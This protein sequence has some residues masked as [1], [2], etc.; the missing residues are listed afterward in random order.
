MNN[1][2]APTPGMAARASGGWHDGRE[3]SRNTP[4]GGSFLAA[5]DESTG[6]SGNMER[7]A[8]IGDGRSGPFTPP[9]GD[10]NGTGITRPIGGGGGVAPE[11]IAGL[12]ETPLAPEEGPWGSATTE[13]G[14]RAV[15]PETPATEADGTLLAEGLVG[16]DISAETEGEFL[17]GSIGGGRITIYNEDNAASELTFRWAKTSDDPSTWNLYYLTNSEAEGD[18]I[19]W[20]RVPTDFVFGED[21]KLTEPG[22]SSVTLAGLSVDG[23]SF[24]D[25]A[26]SFGTNGLSQAADATGEVRIAHLAQNGR[27]EMARAGIVGHVIEPGEEQ[28][29]GGEH[30]VVVVQDGATG[31]DGDNGGGT[32]IT[33]NSADFAIMQRSYIA[34]ALSFGLGARAVDLFS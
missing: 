9:V 32:G 27:D 26:L 23:T 10:G 19:T 31:P 5:M 30:G 14:Y 18:A 13:I 2:L 24:G 29:E 22:G 34:R 33:S 21:G 25:V 28:A 7:I 12:I 8:P 17:A 6:G 1:Y 15:L 4:T 20:T 3:V 11:D 16:V